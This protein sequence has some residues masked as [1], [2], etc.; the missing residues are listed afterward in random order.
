L[1][2]FHF[3]R[4][5]LYLKRALYTQARDAFEQ[6]VLAGQ[7]NPAIH[8]YL[9]QTHFELGDFAKAIEALDR[10]PELARESPGPSLMRAE[11]HWKLKQ[12][13]RALH[14]LDEGGAR[15][16]EFPKLFQLKIGYLIELGLYQEVVRVGDSF[17]SRPNVQALD[18]IAIAEGL[19]RSKQLNE[20]RLIMEHAHLRFPTEMEVGL[21]L[22]SV[23]HD[24]ERPLVSAMLYENAAR[25]D[26][27]YNFEAAELYKDS[28][29]LSR[30]LSLNARILDPQKKLK[31]RLSI[32]LQMERYEMV[33]GM[34]PSLSRAGLIKDESIRYALA[35]GHFKNG[36]FESAEQHLKRL[37]S[38]AIFE[39]ATA[40]RKAMATCREAGW[41][42][43]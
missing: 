21:A 2:K 30:A 1:A 22:A 19:R 13:D 9:A 4:G 7:L 6:S 14:V 34:E 37:S 17:L 35:Y 25:S 23:Y 12:H 41:A 29:R 26:P 3:L 39:K 16:P 36:D 32:L 18:F 43:Y 40:L 42:C 10:A 5:T 20:A 28:G 8:I 27:K 11:A 15:F 24:L 38:P 33:A 31:Q